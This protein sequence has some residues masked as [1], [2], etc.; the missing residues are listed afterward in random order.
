MRPYEAGG[1]YTGPVPV[2]NRAAAGNLP[3]ELT[4]FVG[5]RRLLAEVKAAF[6]G[7]RLLTLV[8][9]AGWAR[10]GSPYAPPLTS[11][12][13]CATASGSSNLPA[14]TTPIWLPRP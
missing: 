5:R 7:T 4:S 6:V 9:P 11:N 12:G 8:G 10:P 1:S 2:A 13:R 14:W 3:A